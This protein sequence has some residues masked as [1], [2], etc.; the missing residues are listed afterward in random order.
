MPDWT[1]DDYPV[2]FW[3]LFGEQGHPIR[4]TVSEMGPLLLA[5]LMNLNEVQEGV[6][7]I[8]FH[9]ADKE[10]LLLLDLDDLQ[11]MLVHC[12]EQRRRADRSN[13][14]MSPSRRSAR[15]SARCS[16][17]AARAA[18][19]SSASRRSTSTISSTLDEQ[20]PRHRQH[21]R[22]RQA[23][24]EPAALRDLPAVAAVASC[25]SSFPR[26]AIPTSRSSSSSSTRRICCSTTRRRRLLE[27]IEQVVRLIRSKGVGVY[28][29]TQNPIDI[30]DKVAG[31]LGNRVQHALH[32]F[33]PRDQKAV[34][35]AADTFRANPGDRRRDRDHRAQDRR[36]AG[37]AAPARRFALAGPAHADQAAVVAGR[38]AHAAGAQGDR[39]HRRDRRQI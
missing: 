24:G 23:D 26:S 25:S 37:F 29:I 6:L 21:P 7:N 13:M 33:T 5:R 8:A 36:G 18:T 32:A 16:S 2:Q 39:H 20:R 9:V 35:A 1:Y 15:S 17:F 14:A 10:G 28:F 31:Q 19:I 3:D 30:P 11:A 22:R 27:K 12:G 38:P 4:T 34:K